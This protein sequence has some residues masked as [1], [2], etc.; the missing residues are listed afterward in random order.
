MWTMIL[1][2]TL[3]FYARLA[4][5]VVFVVSAVTK[6]RDRPGFRVAVGEFGVPSFAVTA[7]AAVVPV[8]ELACAVALVVADP[9]ATTGIVVSL[10]LVATFT[11]AIVANLARGHRPDCHCFGQLSSGPTGW[12]T[13]GRNAAILL[14]AAI[15]L[16]RA[17]SLPSLPRVVAAYTGEQIAVAAALTGLAAAVGALAVF[18]RAL[19][20]RYGAVLLRLEALESHGAPDRL[21]PAPDFA[22]ADLSGAQESLTGLLAG[23]RPAL[24]TFIA[25][26]C[27]LCSELIPDLER[28]QT[29]DHPLAVA[30]IST[31]RPEDNRDKVGAESALRVLLQLNWEIAGAYGIQ[32]TPAAALVGVDGNLVGG[33]A[34]G[35]DEVRALHDSTVAM[36]GGSGSAGGGDLLQVGRRPVEAGDPLPAVTVQTEAGVDSELA[37]LVGDEAVLLFWRTDCGYCSAI[38]GE[39]AELESSTRIVVV[40]GSAPD[41]VRRSGLVSEIARDAAFGVGTALEVP[42][43]P[44]AILVRD[45][46]L[47]SSMAVGGPEV[48]SLLKRVGDSLYAEG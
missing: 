3:V 16:L 22:L 4:L 17:G 24:V 30:V 6:L 7:V 18:C 25:P 10:L 2:T 32:G 34:H 42:G 43:T 46:A 36:M 13:V 26:T 31:G 5:V 28:W 48:L 12:T 21:V 19:L 40:T 44:A 1:V 23:G 29:D 38:S 20:G 27:T 33:I 8:V 47:A 11:V 14:V 37:A 35:L 39:V 45:G 9:V 41:E 15:P